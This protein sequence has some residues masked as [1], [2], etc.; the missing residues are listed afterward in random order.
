MVAIP[1]ELVLLL[2]RRDPPA[3]GHLSSCTYEII[4]DCNE[5][6]KINNNKSLNSYNGPHQNNNITKPYLCW[7]K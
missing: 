6:N 3:D 7:P 4:G 5:G 2:S 1:A